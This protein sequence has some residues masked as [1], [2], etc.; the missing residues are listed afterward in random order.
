M[1]TKPEEATIGY[2]PIPLLIAATLLCLVPF[3]GKPFNIDEPLF[4]WVARHIQSHPLDFYG[5]GINWYGTEM[6]AAEIIKNPPLASYYIA[7]AGYALG[8]DE[9][10]LHLAFLLPAL[11]A[12]T[13][14]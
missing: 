1:T 14:T 9:V 5:F 13:G 8:L 3:I 6:S 2:F 10:S 4:I 11:A 7:M 12:L